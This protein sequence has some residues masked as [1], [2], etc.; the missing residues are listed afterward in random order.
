MGS[1]A[2]AGLT[3]AALGAP[4]GAWFVLSEANTGFSDTRAEHPWILV[5]DFSPRL[6]LAHGCPRTRRRNESEYRHAAHEIGHE[7]MCQLTDTG[8][9]LIT[10][11]RPLDPSWLDDGFYSCTEPSGQV[12]QDLQALAVGGKP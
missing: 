3:H 6:A 12:I 1:L 5:A 11:Q 9:I 2:L 7:P 8:W 4:A 10:Q